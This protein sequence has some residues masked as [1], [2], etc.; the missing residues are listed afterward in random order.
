MLH[1]VANIEGSSFLF[2]AQ[3][4]ALTVLQQSYTSRGQAKCVISCCREG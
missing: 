1:V 3:G 2:A 4:A